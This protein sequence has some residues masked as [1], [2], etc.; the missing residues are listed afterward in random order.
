MSK[1]YWEEE[2][3]I[4][5]DTGENVLR[6]FENAQRLQISYPEW[7]SKDGVKVNGKTVTL[8]IEAGRRLICLGRS[9]GSARTRYR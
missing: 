9:L 1:K 2:E 8:N 6:L 5:V 4:V 7:T 3:P